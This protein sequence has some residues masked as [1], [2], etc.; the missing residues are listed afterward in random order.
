MPDFERVFDQLSVDIAGTKER[1]QYA[2]GFIAGKKKAR[3]EVLIIVVSLYFLIAM[4][5]NLFDT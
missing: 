1:K 5:G 3:I 2:I 4:I